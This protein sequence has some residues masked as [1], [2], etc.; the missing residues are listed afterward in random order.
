LVRAATTTR[1]DMMPLEMKVFW[2]LRIQR[3][4]SLRAV[5]RIP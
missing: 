3:S 2:P 5:V 1:S 4:P